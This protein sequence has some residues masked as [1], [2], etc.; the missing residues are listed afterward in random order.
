MK[1]MVL[2]QLELFLN[3]NFYNKFLMLDDGC[4]ETPQL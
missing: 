4:L 1:N 2:E 3:R